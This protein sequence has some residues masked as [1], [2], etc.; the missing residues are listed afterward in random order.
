MAR[1]NLVDGAKA[2]KDRKF[3]D[4]ENLF[5]YAASLDPNGDTIEGRTAQLSLARTLHSE[6]IGDRSKKTLAESAIAE[7][8]KSIPQTERELKDTEAAYKAN[9][10]SE[11]A[12]A[13][14]FQSL[15][16]LNS[17]TSAV[18]SLYDNI[19][20][21]DDAKAW[22]EKVAANESLPATARARAYSALAAKNNTC[23]NDI[24][25]SPATKKTVTGKDGKSQMYQFSKPASP[26]DFDKLKQCVA[27][28][29][30]LIDKAMALEPDVVKN[31][32]SLNVASMSDAQLALNAEIL[33]VFESVRSYKA[34]LVNQSARVAEMDGN[35]ADKDKLKADYETAKANF[36]SLSDVV[37]KITSLQDERTA[38]KE[39]AAS[40]EANKAN[41]N[42]ANK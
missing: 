33:K 34:S 31:A 1:K 2:Y 6:Y 3:L 16:A 29:Q 4:A 28:G 11:D 39:A 10:N 42:A 9:P 12:Q 19:Q 13:K 5:R 23:A 18:A 24:S 17:S 22:Q 40:A 37:K 32:G 38:A 7:Y 15:S 21:P 30:S 41:A 8:Q 25:D 14:Y 26:E 36:M 20:R 27:D 35:T